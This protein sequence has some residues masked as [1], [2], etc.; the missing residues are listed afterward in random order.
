V[1]ANELLVERGS[2]G[3]D[4][5]GIGKDLKQRSKRRVAATVGSLELNQ[6]APAISEQSDSVDLAEGQAAGSRVTL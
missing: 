3:V 2:V 1:E 4:H 5:R 6:A